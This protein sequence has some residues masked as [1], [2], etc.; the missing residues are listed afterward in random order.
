MDFTVG[1]LVLFFG[2]VMFIGTYR[3]LRRMKA[4]DEDRLG[5]HSQRQDR[6]RSS[7]ETEGPPRE[8]SAFERDKERAEVAEAE[9]R[10]GGGDIS[11]P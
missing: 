3:G 7:L 4:R 10:L 2:S 9:R 6:L 5:R 8:P 1:G 11:M